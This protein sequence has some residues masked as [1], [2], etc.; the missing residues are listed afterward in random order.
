MEDV[1][2][3]MGSIKLQVYGSGLKINVQL[4]TKTREKSAKKHFS[5]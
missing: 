3:N 1:L 4:A 2:N 5:L